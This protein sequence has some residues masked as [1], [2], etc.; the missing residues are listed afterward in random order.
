MLIVTLIYML[1]LILIILYAQRY[2]IFLR[3]IIIVSN[4]YT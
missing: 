4:A 1:I 3:E 2:N